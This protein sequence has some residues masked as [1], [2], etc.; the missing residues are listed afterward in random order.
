M[1]VDANSIVDYLKGRKQA[2]DFQ[3]RRIL[4]GQFDPSEIYTGSVAQNTRLLHALKLGEASPELEFVSSVVPIGGE[5]HAKVLSRSQVLIENGLNL[6]SSN[7]S[8]NATVLLG[9]ASRF[10]LIPLHIRNE[11]ASSLGQLVLLPHDGQV[12]IDWWAVPTQTTEESFIISV[13]DPSVKTLVEQF[14]KHFGDVAEDAAKLAAKDLLQ[15]ANASA[16]LM[17]VFTGTVVVLVTGGTATIVISAQ[18]AQ[19]G[20]DFSAKF[21]EFAIEL[22]PQP[23]Q[24]ADKDTLKALLTAPLTAARVGLSVVNASKTIKDLP[25]LKKNLDLCS[26]IVELNSLTGWSVDRYVVPAE[27]EKDL[28]VAGSLLRSAVGNMISVVCAA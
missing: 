28:Q 10:G 6:T 15:A 19:Y 14:F 16:I 12:R 8:S 9:T 23:S 5:I 24:Q 13:A 26:S 20:L 11:S 25:R 7:A 21:I 4:W 2:S 27:G 17:D 3:S 18:L 22:A 1:G